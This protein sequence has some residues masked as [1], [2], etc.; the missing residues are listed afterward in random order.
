MPKYK[1]MELSEKLTALHGSAVGESA[2]R[3][4]LEGALP[5]ARK[6]ASS[7][8]DEKRQAFSQALTYASV[9]AYWEV[10]QQKESVPWVIFPLSPD[11]DL[12]PLADSAKSLADRIGVIAAELDVMEA[13]YYLGVLYTAM[14][15]EKMR[16]DFGAYYTPPA[17]CERLLDM[18]TES[19]VDWRTAR[20]LDPACGGGAFLSPAAQRMAKNL[21]EC[22]P[23]FVL[24]SIVGRLQGFELD[25]FAAWMSHVFLEMTLGSLCRAAET[26][27][28]SIIDVCNSLERDPH[29]RGFDLVIGN[30]PYGRVKL[31]P[32]L[33]ERYQRSLFGHANLYGVFTDLA[34]RFTKPGGVIAYVTPTSFLAGEYYK[35]LRDLLGTEAPPANIDFINARKGVFSDVLQETLLAVYKRGGQPSVGQVN[36]ISSAAGTSI[37]V[38]SAGSFR[39]PTVPSQPWLVPRHL[40]H[41]NIVHAAETMTYRLSDYG[42]KVSTG[43]LVWNRHKNSLRDELCVGCYPLI[44]AESV[45]SDGMFEFRHEKRNHRP[46]FKPKPEEHWVVTNYP[47]VLLQRTTSKEQSRRLIAAE[48]P[49]SFIDTYGGVVVEN[50]LNMIRPLNGEPRISSVTLAALLATNVI[51]QLFRCINGSVAVSAYELEALPLPEPGAMDRLGRLVHFGAEKAEIEQVVSEMYGMENL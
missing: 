37:D 25:P 42:Y 12:A 32:D 22:S 6:L 7:I 11:L 43:P 39:L 14:M 17:L 26:R 46:Y 10:S 29:G 2:A 21:E 48:L 49:Q 41:T 23:K 47:C 45:R 15:P 33:R 31:S 51:D 4:I 27:L 34:L 20:V 18:A 13:S 28:A 36:F 19:G 38:T 1:E 16:A 5:L 35:A 3:V 50:H 9:V 44:W 40:I 8:S 24:K 30:P